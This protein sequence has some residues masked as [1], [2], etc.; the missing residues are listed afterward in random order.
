LNGEQD[1]MVDFDQRRRRSRRLRA[2]Q[3]AFL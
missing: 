2:G 3:P 1:A